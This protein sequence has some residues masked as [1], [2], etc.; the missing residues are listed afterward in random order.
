MSIDYLKEGDKVILADGTFVEKSEKG[1]IVHN[2]PS[3]KGIIKNTILESWIDLLI[4]DNI[5]TVIDENGEKLLTKEA[6]KQRIIKSCSLQL[7]ISQDKLIKVL[8]IIF[9]AE[10]E[11]IDKNKLLLAQGQQEFLFIS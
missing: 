10:M 5:S 9:T 11:K 6:I 1:I 2:I 8:E 7:N 4:K 3:N